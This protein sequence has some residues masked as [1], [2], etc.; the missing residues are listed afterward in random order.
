[1]V[2]E[3]TTGEYYREVFNAKQEYFDKAGAVHEDDPEYEQRMSIFLDWYIFDRDLPGVDLPPIKYHFKKNRD[4]MGDEDLSVFKDLCNTNHSLFR[5]K[6]KTWKGDAFV[7]QDLFTKKTFTVKD[8]ELKMGFNK[9]DL[10][11]G[12]LIPFKG[13]FTFSRGFCFHPIS[14]EGFILSEIKKIRFQDKSRQTKLILQ[15]AAMKLK[16]SRFQ[17]IDV[18]HIYSFASKF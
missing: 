3:Y 1:M 5:M 17:H 12:R 14:M 18:K 9:G 2:E 7:V 13:I 4:R 11:E 16:H 8:P 15:L 6:R 10:F